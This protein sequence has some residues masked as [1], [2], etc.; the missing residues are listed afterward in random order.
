VSYRLIG[1]IGVVWGAGLLLFN[2]LSRGQAQAQG[3]YAAGQGLGWIF[4]LVLFL[5]GIY[6]L[7]RS[8]QKSPK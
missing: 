7:V 8:P 1:A 5:V 4:G 3:A 2:L 6:Y